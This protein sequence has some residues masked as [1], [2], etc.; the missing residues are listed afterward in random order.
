[1]TGGQDITPIRKREI[2]GYIISYQIIKICS[3]FL[4]KLTT[5][6]NGSVPLSVAIN[7]QI[8]KYMH[9]KTSHQYIVWHAHLDGPR[10]NWPITF[11]FLLI[12]SFYYNILLAATNNHLRLLLLNL[13]GLLVYIQSY[14]ICINNAPAHIYVLIVVIQAYYTAVSISS[15]ILVV[16]LQDLLWHHHHDLL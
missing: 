9:F 15:S 3:F 5:L 1:M 4:K 11:L 2:I 6:L 8:I 13:R 7:H 12:V 14:T 10:Y 16:P